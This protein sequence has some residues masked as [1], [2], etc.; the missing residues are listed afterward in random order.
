MRYTKLYFLL[1][2]MVGFTACTTGP[3][4]G[5]QAMKHIYGEGLLDVVKAPDV[6]SVFRVN[7]MMP[8]L[9]NAS[10]EGPLEVTPQEAQGIIHDFSNPDSYGSL[11]K[12]SP[13]TPAWNAEIVFEKKNHKVS[14]LYSSV[15]GQL[16]IDRQGRNKPADI[17]S[18]NVLIETQSDT[19][20][21]ILQK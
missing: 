21:K 2:V 5:K 12:P 10:L 8:D 1:L 17:L 6:V 7:S 9:K 14:Y 19:L 13:C 20:E 3:M 15:C 18:T 4:T 16:I 11:D